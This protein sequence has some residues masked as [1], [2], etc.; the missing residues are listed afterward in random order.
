MSFLSKNIAFK[1]RINEINQYLS[2][3]FVDRVL[4]VPVINIRKAR[5]SWYGVK[6]MMILKSEKKN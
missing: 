5:N 3:H 4:R 1:L 2:A 6:A